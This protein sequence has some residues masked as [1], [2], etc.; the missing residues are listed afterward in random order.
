MTGVAGFPSTFFGPSATAPHI[1]AATENLRQE[2]RPDKQILRQ[3]K[4]ATMKAIKKVPLIAL[5]VFMWLP[6]AHAAEAWFTA[7]VLRVGLIKTGPTFI[8]LTDLANSPAFIGK[9]FRVP[10]TDTKK[11]M[12]AIALT[13]MSTD[14]PVVVRIDLAE[15]VTPEIK[16]MYL[17]K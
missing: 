17:T 12:L 4:E 3:P 16:V 9:Y 11:E 5:L 10:E 15:F 6:P 13:A 8:R 14:L 7:E 2:K 1:A